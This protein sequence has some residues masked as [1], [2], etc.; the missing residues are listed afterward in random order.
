MPRDYDKELLEAMARELGV[1]SSLAATPPTDGII[2]TLC[3]ELGETHERALRLIER[4]K[5]KTEKR[6]RP[7]KEA[8]GKLRDFAERWSDLNKSLYEGEASVKGIR[9]RIRV[10]C[11]WLN[12]VLGG[13]LGEFRKGLDWDRETAIRARILCRMVESCKSGCL[14]LKGDKVLDAL[15]DYERSVLAP[16]TPNNIGRTLKRLC[17]ACSKAYA[18]YRDLDELIRARKAVNRLEQ[19]YGLARR[20]RG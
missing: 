18:M 20:A 12:S 7:Y 17:N 2:E 13:G 5:R 1:C 3:K 11:K 8:A 16:G 4:A 6:E 14:S 15:L 10:K 9:Q 19:K